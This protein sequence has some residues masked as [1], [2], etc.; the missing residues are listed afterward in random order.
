M[1][2]NPGLIDRESHFPFYFLPAVTVKAFPQMLL[3]GCYV[4]FYCGKVAFLSADSRRMDCEMSNDLSQISVPI[5]FQRMKP[6]RIILNSTFVPGKL[7]HSGFDTEM[8]S[9][10]IL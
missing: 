8:T 10:G 5:V 9:V 6:Q 1:T 3:E 7:L 4:Y 2:F